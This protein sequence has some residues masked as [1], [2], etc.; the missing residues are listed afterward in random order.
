MS[1]Y[2]SSDRPRSRS[3][4]HG[5]YINASPGSASRSHARSMT[6]D[7]DPQGE[8]SPSASDRFGLSRAEIDQVDRTAHEFHLTQEEVMEQYR[9]MEELQTSH[10]QMYPDI[11]TTT[12]APTPA[13]TPT[14]TA[15][16]TIRTNYNMAV[17]TSG[18]GVVSYDPN[19][20]KRSAKKKGEEK[21]YVTRRGNNGDM[22]TS[23]NLTEN[24]SPRTTT[25]VR[26][27]DPPAHFYTQASSTL[28]YGAPSSSGVEDEDNTD[29]VSLTMSQV[30]GTR[31]LFPPKPKD[32]KCQRPLG[33]RIRK[34]LT[35]MPL[36]DRVRKCE[37]VV[38]INQNQ[39]NSDDPIRTQPGMVPPSCMSN[40][41]AHGTSRN[42]LRLPCDSCGQ[43]LVVPKQAILVT[44]HTCLHVRPASLSSSWY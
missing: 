27:A 11:P 30:A 13:P 9:I 22:D 19:T 43:T 31:G 41:R 39:N 44:C 16:A 23:G 2:N 10:S 6:L 4:S 18:H 5:S 17:P 24:T 15:T 3:G 7:D 40:P 26:L 21:R 36:R 1:S 20:I 33:S 34:N 8:S 42:L 12:P 29:A 37:S 38:P 14:S 25:I 28:G 35:V 32:A